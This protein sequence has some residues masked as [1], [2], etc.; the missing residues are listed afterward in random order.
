M[1]INPDVQTCEEEMSLRDNLRMFVVSQRLLVAEAVKVLVAAPGA[2]FQLRIFSV[3]ATCVTAAAQQIDVGVAGGT[4]LQQLF[5]I[6]SG[7]AVPVDYWSEEGFLLPAN[8][9]L[10]ADPAAAGPAWQFLIEYIIED[11]LA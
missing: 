9:A 10:S 3:L 6:P 5:S 11:I 4:V 1:E 7:S 8:T 2:G